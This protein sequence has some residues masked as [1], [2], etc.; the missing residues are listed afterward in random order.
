MTKSF[1]SIFFD[2]SRDRYSLNTDEIFGRPFERNV[3]VWS[4]EVHLPI[5]E[6]AMS[7]QNV[8]LTKYQLRSKSGQNGGFYDQN[9]LPK[10]KSDALVPL[11][12][13]KERRDTSKYGGYN[14]PTISFYTLVRYKLGKKYELTI[15]PIELRVA[16]KYLSDAAFA[17][18]YIKDKLGDGAE[19]ITKPLGNRILRINTLFSLDG[20]EVCLAGKSGV[21]ILLRSMMTPRYEKEWMAYIKRIEN[22]AKKKKNS[23]KYE[24]DEKYDGISKEKNI[25]FY[26]YLV[27]K[28]NGSVYSKI[29]GG[30]PTVCKG[31]RDVFE[32]KDIYDQLNCLENMI[33]Y[34]KTNRTGGCDMSKID[35]KPNEGAVKLSAN[36]SNWKKNY[37]D[38]R[39]IDRSASGLFEKVS[40]NLL[41]LI[42][43]NSK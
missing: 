7:N 2:I 19:E 34:I 37:K 36:I 14:K 15:L 25:R 20:F 41:D 29:P 12:E 4:P 5:V 13:I 39:I 22:V 23:P 26:D 35:G 1:L 33:L 31:K 38:V 27:D 11:K 43:E 8:R 17:E 16:D 3:S 30:R 24:I 32:S 40:V 9:I 28:I 18:K 21:V 6:K 10:G 42:S